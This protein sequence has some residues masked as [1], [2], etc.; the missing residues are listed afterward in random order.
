MKKR[1]PL[2]AI[3]ALLDRE[4][5]MFYFIGVF[6]SSSGPSGVVVQ[7]MILL[8]YTFRFE[9]PMYF[10]CMEVRMCRL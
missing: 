6:I 3:R 8:P 2:H 5:L 4:H 7:C 10:V 1:Y 9:S